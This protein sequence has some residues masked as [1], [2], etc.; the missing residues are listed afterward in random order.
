MTSNLDKPRPDEW[1]RG[2]L[3]PFIEEC[4]NNSI[5]V[6]GN[7]NVVAAQLTAVDSIFSELESVIRPT[8]QSQLVPALLFFRSFGAFRAA[9]MVSLSLPT[10]GFPLQRSC[11]ENAGYAKLISQD[12]DL[13][14]IWLQR[15]E[16]PRKVRSTFTNGRVREAIEKDDK[17]VAAIY[18]QLYERSVDFGAHPN[19]KGVLGNVVPG[20]IDTGNLQFFLLGGDSNTLKLGLKSC[21]QTG[22]CSLRIFNHIFR[23]QFAKVGFNEK[24]EFASRPF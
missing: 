2:Q 24:I 6:V 14:R 12:T 3:F 20:S 1:R 10:D 19:E 13:A 23:E 9:V 18:Q 7:K 15:D 8:S 21:G 5:A 22:I 11:L 16:D 17:Q 4:W